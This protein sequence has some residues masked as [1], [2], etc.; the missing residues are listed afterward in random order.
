MIRYFILF[1]FAIMLSFPALA[2]EGE[3]NFALLMPETTEDVGADEKA[4]KT[5][6]DEKPADI[7]KDAD[8]SEMS[9]DA[10]YERRLKLS[11]DM[12]KIWPVRPKIERAL[13]K[14]AEQIEPQNRM[15]F[16]SA[17]RKA[18]NFNTVEQTSIESMA[19]IFTADEL[20]AMIAFYGSKEG[21]SVSF[22]TDDYERA[23]QP[24]LVKMLD[25][26]ILDTKL[27][28]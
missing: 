12:H 11:R 18:I 9:E 27:G 8:Q 4:N 19:D 14:I 20:K 10:A 15:R 6:E 16:K 2:Q 13:D 22:K 26:A 3:A 21:R 23:L 7:I 25:K 24:V 5:K 17:M 1:S 28:Q